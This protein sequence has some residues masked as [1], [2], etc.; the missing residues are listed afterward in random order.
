MLDEA[1]SP[2]TRGGDGGGGGG[3]N[4]PLALLPCGYSM[5]ISMS[6]LNVCLYYHE[7]RCTVVCTGLAEL[8]H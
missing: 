3:G 8:G 1:G 6:R 7:I 5:L 2:E 4:A